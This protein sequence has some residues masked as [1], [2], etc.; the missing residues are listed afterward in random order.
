MSLSTGTVYG[1]FYILNSL[2][3]VDRVGSSWFVLVLLKVKEN[4]PLQNLGDIFISNHRYQDRGV[5]SVSSITLGAFV[6]V[7]LQTL[8]GICIAQTRR[9]HVQ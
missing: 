7:S 5:F 9:L 4:G 8:F 3:F 1:S 6:I 2:L